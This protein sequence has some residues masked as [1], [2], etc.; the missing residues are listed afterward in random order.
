MSVEK[1]R[2]GFIGMGKRGTRHLDMLSERKDIDIIAIAEPLS[3]QNTLALS[4]LENTNHKPKIYAEGVNDYQKMINNEALDAV[5]IYTPWEFHLEQSVFAMENGVKV[6]LEVSGAK[7]L[8]ECWCY[9]DTFEKTKTPIMFLEN[10]CYRRDVMAIMKMKNKGFFGEL[11]HLR[12]GY[13]HDIREVLFD[14]NLNFGENTESESGWRTPEYL[15][16]NA[17]IYPSHGLGPISIINDINR[18]NRITKVSSMSGKSVGLNNYCNKNHDFKLGDVITTNISCERGETMLLTHNTTLPRPFNLGLMVQG[19][20]GIWQEFSRG[21]FSD[22]MISFQK[23]RK[24]DDEELF[25]EKPNSYLEENDSQIWKENINKITKFGRYDVDYIML[26]DFITSLKKNTPFRIDVYDLATWKAITPL[27]E[28]SIKE[29]SLAIE[30]PDFTRG[31]Y[32]NKKN[33]FIHYE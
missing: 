31:K 6:G 27:S 2:L 8:E 26:D 24:K 32:L 20:E 16:R 15:Y 25:W 1:V 29:N 28:L 12:G 22:G 11:V 13:Q 30:M 5:L 3:N 19:T 18:G 33:K 14:E 4:I 10:C 17:D 7:T 23:N 21:N 9:V